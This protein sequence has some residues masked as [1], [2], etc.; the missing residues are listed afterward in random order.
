MASASPSPDA[1]APDWSTQREEVLC[2]LCDYNLRGL[3][4]PRCPECGYRF[5]WPELLEERRRR[6]PYLFEQPL[7]RPI[8]SFFRTAW[9]G[10]APASFWKSIHPALPVRPVRLLLY[11]GL[12][13]LPLLLGLAVA[14]F[15]AIQTWLANRRSISPPAARWFA[16][17]MLDC[18]WNLAAWYC[19]PILLL[20]T[21]LVFQISMRRARV[22]FVHVLRC[23]I[24]SCDSILF[25]GLPV[26]AFAIE[27]CLQTPGSGS[28]LTPLLRSL[29]LLGSYSEVLD[30][31]V[32]WTCALWLVL[33]TWRLR[34]AYRHYLRFDHPLATV[35]VSQIIVLLAVVTILV[36]IEQ[37]LH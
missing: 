10:M 24:Y 33:T 20:L 18:G 21:L 28:G 35:V 16:R 7:R 29:N 17:V 30:V 12:I 36:R 37:S 15:V 1:A 9:G 6:H 26:L 25:L 31:W 5:T 13:S 32:G 11:W 4:E 34:Q 8:W 22:K 14:E 3:S 27:R 19:W 2:P 23:L